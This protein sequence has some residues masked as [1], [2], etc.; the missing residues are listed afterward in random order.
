MRPRYGV[1]AG[2]MLL[3]VAGVAVLMR[4][5]GARP[6]V[7]TV[8]VGVSPSSVAVD[9]RTHHVF[10]TNWGDNTVSMLDAASGR[11]VRVAAVGHTP[12]AVAVG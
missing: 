9:P 8:T 3:A 11:V 10:V 5:L 4:P 6:L 2:I 1:G 7:D 12:S